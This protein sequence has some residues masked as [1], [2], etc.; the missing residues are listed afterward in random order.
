MIPPTPWAVQLSLTDQGRD[1]TRRAIV[2]VHQLA[3]QL[4]APL[5]G[6]DG[7]RTEAFV[8]ELRT[9]LEVPLESPTKE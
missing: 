1:V 7:R 3:D 4:L 6:L 8:K 9:L 5:G 2:I